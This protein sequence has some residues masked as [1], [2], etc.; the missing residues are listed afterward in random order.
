MPAIK[1]VHSDTFSLLLV[2][3]KI[4]N[5]NQYKDLR[6]VTSG[7]LTPAMTFITLSILLLLVLVQST[8]S[9]GYLPSRTS[10]LVANPMSLPFLTYQKNGILIDYPSTWRIKEIGSPPTYN[11]TDIV[12]F[13]PSIGATSAEVTM[14]LDTSI[15]NESLTSYLSDIIAS[16]DKDEKDFKVIDANTISTMSNNPAYSLH[17]GYVDNGT[18]YQTLETG[19]KIDNKV[20]FIS[21]DVESSN[22]AAYLPSIQKIME[23]FKVLSLKDL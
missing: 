1:I 14:S 15:G 11:I 21:Y 5:S 2:R 12:R 6:L 9:Y 19:T 17:T 22:Y 8:D 16:E 3:I 13:Y 18:A 20:Y 10:T 7:E 23:S 4:Q